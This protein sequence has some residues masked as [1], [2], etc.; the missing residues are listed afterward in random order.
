MAL[1]ATCEILK[2]AMETSAEA[3]LRFP[4]GI[5]ISLLLFVRGFEISMGPASQG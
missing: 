4:S 5:G 1:L 2:V 3:V